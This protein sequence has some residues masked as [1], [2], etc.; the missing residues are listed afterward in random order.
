MTGRRPSLHAF[1]FFTFTAWFAYGVTCT[2]AATNDAT[3]TRTARFE[4]DMRAEIAAGR[5]DVTRDQVGV[6]GAATPLSWS[7][8]TLATPLGDGR[9][10]V[11]VAINRPVV[12]GQPLAYK[13]KIDRPSFGPDEGWEDGR[14]RVIL[15]R[16]PTEIVARVFNAPPGPVPMERVGTIDRLS[17]MPSEFVAS[18]PVQVWLPPGYTRENKRRYPVLYLHDGQTMFDAAAAGAEWQFDETAQRLILAGSIEPVIIVAVANTD[19]RKDEYTPTSMLLPAARSGLPTDQRVGGAADKYARYLIEELKP[20]IDRRYRTLRD[21][22]HTAVG[23]ASLGGLVTMWLTLHHS[24]VF[25]AGLVVSPSVWWDDQIIVRDAETAVL[26]G[27]NRPKIWLD[28]GTMEGAEALPFT[29]QLR[30][31]LTARGWNAQ[32][33]SYLEQ[34]GGTHDEESWARRVEGM[35]RFLHGRPAR[36]Q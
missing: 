15:L 36:E 27:S 24:D 26:A 3:N 31:T 20:M 32:T 21:A 12:G 25:G 13:F 29:R 14:N 9:F 34:D 8:T 17:P 33:L 22:K 35:L 11:T 6:R 19:A 1:L 10:A 2:H 7:Q 28:I 23:G 16:T 30:D 18:R 5:F 4:I